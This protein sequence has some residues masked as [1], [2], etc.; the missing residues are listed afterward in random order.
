MS[1]SKPTSNLPSP[2]HAGPNPRP[3]F[4][5]IELLVVIAV[6]ALLI[7]ILLPSLG[8]ARG[9]ARRVVCSSNLRQIAIA[10]TGYGAENK[11][12]I[13][14]SPVTSG[15]AAA[16]AATAKSD[17]VFNGVSMQSWDWM[18]PLAVSMGMRPPNEGSSTGGT[19][20]EER[21]QRVDWYR[22]SMKSFICPE[23]NI[24]AGPYDG[25]SGSTK[26]FTVGRMISYNMS[27]QYTSI[28]GAAATVVGGTGT[29]SYLDR[30]GYSPF[31]YKMGTPNMKALVF[32]GHRFGELKFA[33]AEFDFETSIDAD[34]GGAFGGTGP[35]YND[36]KEL[37]R[38]YAPGEGLSG[39]GIV[40]LRRFAFRH[41]SKT[42]QGAAGAT[43]G[44]VL[45]LG[46]VGF[47]DGHAE[48]MDD[49]KATNPD[50]WFPTGT[51]I[52]NGY[53]SRTWKYARDTW[54]DKMGVSKTYIV[55]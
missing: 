3:G 46:N 11:D 55:P 43:G 39:F 10:F 36:N 15:R 34:Y 1:N 47:A 33:K 35:W 48:T 9:V 5:L 18:G 38:K 7:S 22:N 12:A 45:C 51:K 13:A 28:E 42:S 53:A 31:L 26:E 4:T 37:S 27:T 25:S 40:D 52:K 6:I 8:A 19:A 49:A 17:G 44:G 54:P 16:G 23:N 2:R 32:E 20:D 21:S 14:G 30:A 50:Y 29:Y 24:S 41:G